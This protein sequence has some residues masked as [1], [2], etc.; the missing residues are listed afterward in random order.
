MSIL[1]HDGDELIKGTVDGLGGKSREGEKE[2]SEEQKSICNEMK[3]ARK[4]R[5]KGG[6]SRRRRTAL[7]EEGR[8][9]ERKGRKGY[10]PASPFKKVFS[11]NSRSCLALF[12]IDLDIHTYR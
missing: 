9:E 12:C 10:L 7:W 8:K 3:E 4:E 5:K 6:L 2:K 1:L 11:I